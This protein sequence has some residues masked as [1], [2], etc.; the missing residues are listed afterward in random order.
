MIF[1]S[2]SWQLGVEFEVM[3]VLLLRPPYLEQLLRV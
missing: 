3:A 2:G 1:K